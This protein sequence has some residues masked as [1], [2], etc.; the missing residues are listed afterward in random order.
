MSVEPSQLI[1]QIRDCK[2]SYDI[3]S[4]SAYLVPQGLRRDGPIHLPG[5]TNNVNAV[6][7]RM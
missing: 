6:S 2:L 4:K 7:K 5:Q 1:S 3:A